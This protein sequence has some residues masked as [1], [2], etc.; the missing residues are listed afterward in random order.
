M[1]VNRSD[2]YYY[3]TRFI[4]LQ[5]MRKNAKS[6]LMKVLLI[7]I[8]AVFVLYFGA[9]R[10]SRTAETIAVIGDR[11][12]A[13]AEFQREYQDTLDAIRVRYGNNLTDDL[14][15]SLKPKEQAYNQLIDRAVLLY[16]AD[17]MDLSVDNEELRQLIVS[18]PAFRI[19][20]V[21][22]QNRY[23]QVLRQNRLTPEDFEDMQRRSLIIRKMENLITESIKIS[24][25]EVYELYRMQNEKVNL[26]ALTIPAED[27]RKSIKPTKD[28]LA[29][30]LKDHAENFRRPKTIDTSYAFY[31]AREFG[32]FFN[33][34]EKL[35]EDYYA[36]HRAS[37]TN[38]NGEE[39]SL[40]EVRPEIIENLQLMRG[41]DLAAQAAKEAH[42]II[43]QEENF[44]AY[45][46]DSGVETADASFVYGEKIP[47]R[48]QK[49]ANLSDELFSR[50]GGDISPVLCDDTGCYVFHIDIVHP[51]SIPALEEIE[52]AVT[53]AYVTD[54]ANQKSMEKA[55]ALLTRIQNG[56]PIS[57][58]AAEKGVLFI[59][60]GLFVPDADIPKIGYAPE[61]AQ[62]LFD[63][64][65]Q[66]PHGEKPFFV[67][68]RAVIIS[69]TERGDVDETKWASERDTMRQYLVRMKERQYFASW[70]DDTKKRLM[71]EK[72]LQ[73][74]KDISMI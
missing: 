1:A 24:D 25:N 52:S 32:R 65:E 56:E 66:N 48:F 16:M 37:F 28:D 61:I 42:D 43:Y 68:G 14:L 41:L 50:E 71:A 13:Y 23:I 21:F 36:S 38:E 51:P 29:A 60:T 10:G 53:E 74:K 67:D 30:Y 35:I 11:H 59:E 22:D 44:D 55:G 39:K 15:K 49:L 7:I 6:W 18:Y 5:I 54:M 73:I 47:P 46:K 31:A 20:D 58:I 64:T 4:M 72:V 45:I 63:L 69:L 17:T 26:A 33:A 34:S 19:N 2:D 62:A 8:C 57:K 3:R 9:M 12:I 27:F 40:A 70:L